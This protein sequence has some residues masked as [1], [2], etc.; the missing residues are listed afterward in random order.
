MANR[1]HDSAVEL[2]LDSSLKTRVF[3]KCIET[4]YRHGPQVFI[5]NT[6]NAT[7]VAALIWTIDRTW[8]V[9]A[10]WGSMIAMVGIRLVI[11][12]LMKHSLAG[13]EAG[14]CAQLAVFGSL[15]AGVLWGA[16]MVAL[17]PSDHVQGQLLLAFVVGGMAS[18]ASSSI[19]SYLPAFYAFLFPATVPLAIR[20]ALENDPFYWGMAGAVALFTGMVTLIGR[21]THFTL[22]QAYALQFEN[23]SLIS[24]LNKTRTTLEQ[25]VA[26]RTQ[27][28]QEETRSKAEITAQLQHAQKLEAVGRLTGGVAHDFNNLLTVIVSSLEQL[29]DEVDEATQSELVHPAL[30][31]AL[32]GGELTRN[33][34]AF[35]RKQELRPKV[36]NAHKV[37]TKLATNI[38][39]RTLPES[40][41]ITLNEPELR[42]PM[43]L[44]VD[45][46]QLETALLNLALNARDA[47]P[48][49]GDLELS[50][51]PLTLEADDVW[52]VDPGEYVELRVRDEGTGIGADIL[53]RVFEPFFT[54]K[55]EHGS[56]LGLSMVYG[57]TR[58]SGGSVHLTSN[59]GEGTTV[60]LLLPRYIRAQASEHQVKRVQQTTW[61]GHGETILIVEDETQV[62]DLTL[63]ILRGLGYQPLAAANATD[64]LAILNDQDVDLVLTDIVMPGP[65]DGIDLAATIQQQTPSLP[66][67]L[68]SGYSEGTRRSTEWPLLPK[69]YRRTELAQTIRNMLDQTVIATP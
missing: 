65:L 66:V 33:L 47:M 63:Q 69:P 8:V 19:A 68:V 55:G 15:S 32:R 60:S 17:F 22:I 39:R 25:R 20:F 24:R 48:N 34:L 36:V 31:A 2:R 3:A 4:L 43:L 23:E 42:K 40:I 16:G 28:L 57:F 54:T 52:Q 7:L 37:V 30:Q 21:S 67:L 53:D 13:V 51:R 1:P 9:I 38:L 11:R 59:P 50:A 14:R 5:A 6:I 45:P 44:K 49:G 29:E 27:Q 62:R 10:W 41:H 64:A 46:S 61:S 12:R 58:Q 18:G 26:E 35:S 56:G